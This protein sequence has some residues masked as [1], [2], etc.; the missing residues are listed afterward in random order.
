[1]RNRSG[2]SRLSSWPFASAWH[3]LI[4]TCQ[5]HPARR[6]F[7]PRLPTARAVSI[8]LPVAAICI[9]LP[10]SQVLIDRI[11]WRDAYQL[12]CIVAAVPAVSAALFAVAAVC[13]LRAASSVRR[14]I[15]VS[16]M[17]AGVAGRCV[18]TP[19]PE[20]KKKRRGRFLALFLHLLFT[21]S[22]CIDHPRDRRLMSERLPLR[23]LQ[24]RPPG[25]LA[26]IVVFI[27]MLVVSTSTCITAACRR[28]CSATASLD[29]RHQSCCGLIQWYP[30]FWL[31]TGFVV[32]FGR[33]IVSRGPARL[34][35]GTALKIFRG[36]RVGTIFGTD[37]RSAPDWI[38]DRFLEWRPIH[39]FSHAIIR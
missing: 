26:A 38:G 11:G 36:K 32:C 2:S 23:R 27:G 31:L 35:G 9:L 10:A 21:R 24:A 33:M 5:L 39:D 15:P 25:A 13:H 17:K 30:N 28:C 37:M 6:W 34:R 29:R 4:A 1:M 14:P 22:R 12:F 3:A 20:Q 19:P 18:T 16:T 7:G 8:P